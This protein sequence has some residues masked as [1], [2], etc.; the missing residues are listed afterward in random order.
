MTTPAGLL[1]RVVAKVVDLVLA[2]VAVELLH[3]TGLIAGLVY[4][5]TADGFFN[6]RSPGKMLL[7]LS[8]VR[9]DGGRCTVKESIL[10]N[11]TVA[12]GFLLWRVPLIGWLLFLA[13]LAFEFIVLYGSDT[14]RRLGDEIAKTNVMEVAGDKGDVGGG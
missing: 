6:G 12:L 4:I 11:L 9:A 14:N 3:E 10:R 5:L 1:S 7:G 8:V 2:A 13:V